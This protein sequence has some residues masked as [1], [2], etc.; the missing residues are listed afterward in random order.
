MSNSSAPFAKGT[1][2]LEE[3]V[4]ILNDRVN[5]SLTIVGAI[6]TNCHSR[7]SITEQVREEV[8]RLYTDLGQVRSDSKLLYATTEGNI[9]RLKASAAMDD[10]GHVLDRLSEVCPWLRS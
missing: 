5:P 10:Y 8:R 3:A 9:L 2:H 6:M 4:S 7:R 1:S